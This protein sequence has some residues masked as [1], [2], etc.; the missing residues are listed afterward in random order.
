VPVASA[1]TADKHPTPTMDRHRWQRRTQALSAE[2]IRMTTHMVLRVPG[3]SICQQRYRMLTVV[4]T[5]PQIKAWTTR[6]TSNISAKGT[7]FRTI[8]VPPIYG[9]YFLTLLMLPL[10]T[11]RLLGTLPR[12]SLPEWISITIVSFSS[13][14]SLRG[15]H[16]FG[17]R[18]VI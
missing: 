12:F 7:G 3:G 18:S 13:M 6:L 1:T 9:C 11:A 2:S 8:P 10:T 5:R 16:L 17:N 15:A 14:E 4:S